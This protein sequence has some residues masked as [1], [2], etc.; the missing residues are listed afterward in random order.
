M[1]GL[2]V[3][4]FL[5]LSFAASIAGAGIVYTGSLSS[6]T[7]GIGGTGIWID[8][9]SLPEDE[10]P[11]WTPATMDWTVSQNPDMSWHYSYEMSVYRGD[12]SHLI[13]ETSPNFTSSD[14]FGYSGDF[15]VSSY[16]PGNS[17]PNM[18]GGVY[19]VKFD[20]LDNT[21][22]TIAFDSWRVPVWGD[23]YAKDGQAGGNMNS[24][25][26]T[27]FLDS[28]PTGDPSSGSLSYHILVP[29]TDTVVPEPT[30]LALLALGLPALGLP[31]LGFYFRRRRS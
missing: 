30:S 29:D 8:P 24:A 6:D 15:E 20:D 4:S 27:G 2:A 28:D 22:E 16:S 17:N 10:Q 11:S 1:R 12:I 3:L 25:W 21:T 9:T 31:A 26:N 19:G 5:L 7:G 14:I 13:I 23:F 18:P